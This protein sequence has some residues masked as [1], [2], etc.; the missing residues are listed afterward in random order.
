MHGR[1]VLGA[2][3]VETREQLMLPSLG[4]DGAGSV[5]QVLHTH[6]TACL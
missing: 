6:S 2:L 5:L 3:S 1:C 4:G